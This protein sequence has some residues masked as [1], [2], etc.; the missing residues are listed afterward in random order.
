ML[1]AGHK[2]SCCGEAALAARFPTR[3]DCY[4]RMAGHGHSAVGCTH[5]LSVIINVSNRLVSQS[6]LLQALRPQRSVETLDNVFSSKNPSAILSNRNA[7]MQSALPIT[8]LT[9]HKFFEFKRHC[10][11]REFLPL[12][13]MIGQPYHPTQPSKQN[14][15]SPISSPDAS[16]KSFNAHAISRVRLAFFQCVHGQLAQ[17]IIDFVCFLFFWCLF[18]GDERAH[19]LPFVSR[20][21]QDTNP[22]LKLSVLANVGPSSSR[23]VAENSAQLCGFAAEHLHPK[24]LCFAVAWEKKQLW[25]KK[26]KSSLVEPVA[27]SCLSGRTMPLPCPST[28]STRS[29]TEGYE[30]EM[31]EVPGLTG[32][33]R[34][35]V[36]K[37]EVTY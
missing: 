26:W 3:T 32:S 12:A 4:H 14:A 24:H 29:E 19:C 31:P 13:N 7:K 8:T 15:A 9:Q 2:A 23:P 36:I 22:G 30:S 27:V 18:V 21:L 25:R 10:S 17:T 37:D 11:S 33:A 35:R 6:W 28:P 16:L 34:V 5:S 20:L 1:G